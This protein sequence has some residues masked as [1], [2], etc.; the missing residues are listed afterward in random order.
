MWK[1]SKIFKYI[2]NYY[3]FSYSKKVI[4]LKPRTNLKGNVLISYIVTPFLIKKNKGFPTSHTN[5]WECYQ[6]AKTFLDEGFNVD[7]INWDNKDF[8]PKLDYKV[9]IDIH[10]NMERISQ[11]LNKNCIKILHI[12]GA[13]WIYQNY[14]EYQRLIDIR[15]VKNVALIPRRITPPSQ[16]IEFADIATT[17]GNE[18]TV[19]TFEYSH[20]AVHRIPISSSVLFDFPEDKN[21][22]KCRKSFLWFGSTGLVLKGLDIVLGAFKKLPDFKLFVCG[23]IKEE[24]DF[25]KAFFKELYETDNIFTLGWVDLESAKFKELYESCIGIV[26][27]SFSEGGG[28]SVINCMQAGLIPIIS[29]ES[30]VDIGEFGFLIEEISVDSI[31]NIVQK[32]SSL[33]GVELKLRS[34]KTWE[35]VRRVHTKDNF[36]K[37]YK[38]FVKENLNI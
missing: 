21:F 26:Y 7:V 37:E 27:P 13:H 12:T 38:K 31:V 20:K 14:K 22:E 9:F 29:K 19:S 25:E 10:S 32:I 2:S 28:G 33:D 3:K 17:I 11:Y 5:Q 4:H 30:S 15:K 8:L 16:G 35:Y 6:I 23:P 34:K 18:F 36:A 24:N 1:I